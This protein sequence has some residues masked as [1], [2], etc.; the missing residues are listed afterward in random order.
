MKNDII[1]KIIFVVIENYFF[2]IRKK[3]IVSF[4]F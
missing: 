1:I 3:R 4:S 2:L